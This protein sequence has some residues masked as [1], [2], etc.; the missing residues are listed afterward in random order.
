MEGRRKFR[1]RLAIWTVAAC[2]SAL[3][4]TGPA[5][6][7]VAPRRGTL[8]RVP[9]SLSD[10]SHGMGLI[11]T[12]PALLSAAEK[13][14]VH[15]EAAA[16]PAS[17]DLTSFAM[18]VGNQGPVG[19]CAA[20]AADYSALGYWENKQGIP[21]GG[22]AP[23][24]TYSQLTGGHDV[25]STIEGNL[26]IDEKGVDNQTD[27]YQGNYNYTSM[28]T[29]G[30][31]TDAVNWKLTGF[32]DLPIQPS[33]SSTVTAQSIETALAAGLPVVIGIPVYDNFFSVGSANHGYYAGVSGRFDGN[34]AIT[35]LGYNSQ[36]LVIENSWG[37]G[38]GNAGWATLSWSFVNSAV[39]DAVSV[40]P[41]HTGQPV[42]TV[43]PSLPY[44]AREGVT[45]TAP[46][47]TWAPAATSYAY[48]WQR[49]TGS[50]WANISGA[51]AAGYTPGTADLGQYL[52]VL[53]TASNVSGPGATTSVPTGTVLSG[54]PADTVLPAVSGS[55]SVGQS[56]TS[57]TGNW[58][59]AGTSWSYQ[60]QRLQ[61]GAWANIPGATGSGYKTTAGDAGAYVRMKLTENNAWGSTTAYSAQVGP[62][63]GVP[64]NA[65]APS[66][67][68]TPVRGTT[69]TVSLGSWYGAPASYTYQWQKYAN[70]GSGWSNISGA[71]ASTYT[72]L[73][74]DETSALR[75]QVTG[76][77]SYGQA[78]AT[79]AATAAVKASPPVNTAAP[80]VL[81]IAALGHTLSIS[82]GTWSGAGNSYT[83]Q[84]QRYVG[85]AWSA[86]TGATGAT[87]APTSSDH[88]ATIR[89]LVTA[90]NLDGSATVAS[91]ATLRVP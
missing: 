50:A 2:A 5:S 24:Y 19:S 64:V 90:T 87:Y 80:N 8:A 25:G 34:H 44:T 10:R 83:Y 6:A 45:L 72:P 67:V 58:N 81:G 59:P 84:W 63:S 76:T 14:T 62:I 7:S 9:L 36:G 60:W 65:S 75:V 91:P 21:G 12:T 39:F 15:A 46:A 30:E 49:E 31:K 71:T 37:T 32:S 40:S 68:G 79:S 41:L 13:A 89:A 73:K 35:A 20:W 26:S 86:I 1:F 61:E 42:S 3:L 27:Y 66:V 51:T 38:W 74:A 4:L 22:L 47:G 56:L 53:I 52:R 85:G 17:V 48:Q 33:S 82:T 23:M 88:G 16:L 43:R 18:P 55:L 11:K 78:V 70:G 57:T 29:A 54:A 69:L 28:P 77:N